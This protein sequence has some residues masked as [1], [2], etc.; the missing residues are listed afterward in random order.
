MSLPI[1]TQR[2]RLRPFVDDDL[3][4]LHTTLFGEPVVMRYIDARPASRT[5]EETRPHLE[6]ILQHQ[7]A[8][9]FADWAACDRASGL[10]LGLCG[11]RLMEYRG[12]EIELSYLLGQAFWGRGYAA[13]AARAA[14]EYGH[15]EL[16]FAEIT[17][18]INPQNVASIRVAERCGMVYVGT[19]HHYGGEMLCYAS[20]GRGGLETPSRET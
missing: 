7:R 19:S 15:D 16:R 3:A 20:T 12:P 9:G 5:I 11:I 8:H 13:E 4:V 17:A 18:I 1:E 14:L 2:L 10:F 6:R